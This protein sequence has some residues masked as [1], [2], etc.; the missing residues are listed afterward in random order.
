MAYLQLL[1]LLSFKCFIF[2]SKLT[3]VTKM[4]MVNIH[5]PGIFYIYLNLAK[6]FSKGYISSLLFYN[7]LKVSFLSF[8]SWFPF[9][10]CP[11]LAIGLFVVISLILG[12][13]HVFL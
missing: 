8:S 6:L 10:V 11:S 3:C 2:N 4:C 5:K 7:G 1:E 9:L 12:L 13:V